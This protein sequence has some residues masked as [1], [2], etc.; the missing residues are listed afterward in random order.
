MLLCFI[1]EVRYCNSSQKVQQMRIETCIKK[2]RQRYVQHIPTLISL[3]SPSKVQTLSV[4]STF[5]KTYC[6]FATCSTLFKF[7][8]VVPPALSTFLMYFSKAASFR[9]AIFSAKE[10]LKF[11]CILSP[12]LASFFPGGPLAEQDPRTRMRNNL[13]SSSEQLRY[14]CKMTFTVKVRT[15]CESK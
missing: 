11:L 4:S 7:T 5:I 14:S 9:F 13:V 6:P 3:N 1:D 2:F 15:N 8:P 12:G 10:F